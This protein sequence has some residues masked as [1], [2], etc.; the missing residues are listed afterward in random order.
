MRLDEKEKVIHVTY[1]YVKD[2]NVLPDNRSQVIAMA[3]GQERRL[4]K[5]GHLEAYNK[6]LQKFIDRGCV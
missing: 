5:L 3:K 1:P 6:E 2:P 4:R